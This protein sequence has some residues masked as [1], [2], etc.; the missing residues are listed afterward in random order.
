METLV[1]IPGT[2]GGGL[3][4]I[5]GDRSSDFIQYL[6]LLEVIDAAGTFQQRERD[7]LADAGRQR[8]DPC[9]VAAEFEMEADAPGAIVKRLARPGFNATPAS[10]SA[11]RRPGSSSRICAA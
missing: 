3:R 4:H 2:V 11:F 7:D 6:R 1:G 9:V 10:R 8:D 5:V